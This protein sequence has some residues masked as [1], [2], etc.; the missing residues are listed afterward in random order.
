MI[1]YSV[2]HTQSPAGLP[3]ISVTTPDSLVEFELRM[4]SWF[5]VVSVAGPG[6]RT[7]DVVV[8][9]MDFIQEDLA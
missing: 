4:G 8:E 6:R 1:T 3:V 2:E 7:A 5:P 9:A